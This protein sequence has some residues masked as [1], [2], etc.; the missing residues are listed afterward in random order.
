MHGG[1]LRRELS[2]RRFLG[3][4][5]AA[6]A[7]MYGG[8]AWAAA[9][10]TP[11]ERRLGFYNLHTGESFE[12]PYWAEG[13]YVP[14]QLAAI[15]K[16]L[17]DFRTGQEHDIDPRLLDLLVTL[18]GRLETGQPLQVISGYRSPKTN[19]MLHEESKGVAAHSYHMKGMAIDVRIPGVRLAALRDSAR[20][21]SSGGVG[22]YPKSDF[23]HID[24]GPVRH[25]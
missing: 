17:R 8:R 19:A 23:V 5:L 9:P 15:R 25:W 7:T 18:R 22:Y 24:V 14:E 3:V 4:G 12:G 10:A 2:R 1:S 20:A 13:A 11:A 6:V 21:A 16:V